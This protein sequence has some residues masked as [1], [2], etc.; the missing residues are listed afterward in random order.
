V[1]A[2]QQS[3]VD[4]ETLELVQRAQG[5]EL[6]AFNTLVI[7]HQDAAYS[8]A[9]R[10][11]RSRESAEDVTQEA[12]LRAY[13]ALESFRGERFR[14]WLLRIVANA[15]RDELRRRKRRPQRSLDEARDDPDMPSIDP[16]EPGL[17]PEQRA[18]QSDLR[19]VLEDALAQLPEDWRLVVLL[20]DVHGLSYDEVAESAGLPLGTVKSRLSR[21]RARLR[22]ILRES[23]ELPELAQRRKT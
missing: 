16:V 18:E 11:L 21:A 17:G 20:S 3:T 5:G 8:L 14:S 13:R 6:A 7:R 23:G 1:A 10:F 4:D 22:E 12:F 9:F 15:A 19:R 2:P